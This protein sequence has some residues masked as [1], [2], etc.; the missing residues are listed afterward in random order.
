MFIRFRGCD[1]CP[2]CHSRKAAQPLSEHG[3]NA[4]C[5]EP[6]PWKVPGLQDSSQLSTQSHILAIAIPRGNAIAKKV[7]LSRQ[8]AAFLEALAFS[9][10]LAPRTLQKIAQPL[11]FIVVER[12]CVSDIFGQN[13]EN[14]AE[15]HG[16][17]LCL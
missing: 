2:K 14:G 5:A 13:H 16:K 17:A 8:L 4:K 9:R 10:V 3:P 12:F 15:R 11:C 1:F 7:T 6:E